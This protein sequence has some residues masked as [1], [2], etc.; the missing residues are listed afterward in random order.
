MSCFVIYYGLFFG[1]KHFMTRYLCALAP[2]LAIYSATLALYVFSKYRN[3]M[4]I[5][6]TLVSVVVT[7]IIVGLN[8]RIYHNGVPHQHFQ[9]VAWVNDNVCMH[10]SNR[11]N[12]AGNWV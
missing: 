3:K 2:F 10:G 9:V 7:L 6:I 5:L 4:K 8:M 11:G 1:A 12:P